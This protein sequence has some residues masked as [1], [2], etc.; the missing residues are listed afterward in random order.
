M[1]EPGPIGQRETAADACAR[2]LRGAILRGELAAGDKLPPERQLAESMGVNR[3]TLRNALAQLAAAGLVSVKQGSGYRVQ[4]FRRVGGLDLLPGLMQLSA[5]RGDVAALAGELLF[6]RRHLAAAVLERVALESDAN[7]LAQ[8][9]DAVA[10]FAAVVEAD[11]D[12]RAIAEADLNVLAA[13]LDATGSPVMALCL[14]PVVSV[15]ANFDQLR[16]A[17]YAEPRS[18]VAGYQL[19]LGWL[20]EPNPALIG[21]ISEELTRRDERTLRRIREANQ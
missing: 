18:N 10:A 21:A 6:L 14:N 5:E 7:K 2:V 17:M 15:L 12:Q 13:L 11:G 3:L 20:D 19:L 1:F 8:V 9:R 16:E 4:D